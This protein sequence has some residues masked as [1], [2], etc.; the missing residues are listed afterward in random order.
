MDPGKSMFEE[1]DDDFYTNQNQTIEE[2]F[3]TAPDL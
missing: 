2:S 3:Y 1:A